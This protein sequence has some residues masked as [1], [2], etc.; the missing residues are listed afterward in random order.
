[1]Y[2]VHKVPLGS[3]R[4]PGGSTSPPWL[5]RH[6][7]H[8]LDGGGGDRSPISR[9]SDHLQPRSF[10]ETGDLERWIVPKLIG[11][12][13]Q[14]HNSPPRRIVRKTQNRQ[15]CPMGVFSHGRAVYHVSL[16]GQCALLS[17]SDPA[18]T[19]FGNGVPDVRVFVIGREVVYPSLHWRRDQ[20]RAPIRGL[21]LGSIASQLMGV[22]SKMSHGSSGSSIAPSARGERTAWTS[23]LCR[24]RPRSSAWVPPC[25][26]L[27]QNPVHG[28]LETRRHSVLSGWQ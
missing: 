7:W 8:S 23:R 15:S 25:W 16:E 27:V 13:F 9:P 24:G 17:P 2:N 21:S 26:F 3:R 28:S 14:E 1:M 20:V 18:A 19:G 22:C 5:N 11:L 4:E 12:W 10:A 6:Y